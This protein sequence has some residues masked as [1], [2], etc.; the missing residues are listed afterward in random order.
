[1]CVCK[2]EVH[3]MNTGWCRVIGYLVL[4][5]RIPCLGRSFSAKEP[6]IICGSVAKNKLQLKAPC[7]FDTLYGVATISRLLKIICLF[8]KR[9]LWKRLYFAKETYDFKEHTN[10]SHPIR[11]VTY[12]LPAMSCDIYICMYMEYMYEFEMIGLFCKRAL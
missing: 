6:Y 7:D 8:C 9:A 11:I 5:H 10:R 3:V 1:M 2:K 4:S 12:V